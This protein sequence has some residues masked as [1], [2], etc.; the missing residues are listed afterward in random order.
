MFVFTLGL[1][2]PYAEIF[3]EMPRYLRASAASINVTVSTKVYSSATIVN[4]AAQPDRPFLSDYRPF[5]IPLGA[6]QLS[7]VQCLIAAAQRGGEGNGIALEKTGAS[8]SGG[9]TYSRSGPPEER[10]GL[11]ALAETARVLSC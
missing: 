8:G 6:K 9:F 2:Q 11:P 4:E 1:Q 7:Q 10:S 3:V 5:L